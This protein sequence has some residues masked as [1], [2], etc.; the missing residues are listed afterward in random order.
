MNE[1]ADLLR[2]PASPHL[3]VLG[4]TDTAV[5]LAA[6]AAAAVARLYQR[7]RWPAHPVRRV[8]YTDLS[9]AGTALGLMVAI[10][11]IAHLSGLQVYGSGLASDLAVGVILVAG[12]WVALEWRL[13]IR[14]LLAKYDRRFPETG[15]R[16]ATAVRARMPRQEGPFL[17]AVATGFVAYAAFVWHPWSH[18]LHEGNWIPGALAGYALGCI[19][20]IRRT[21]VPMPSQPAPVR[22]RRRRR[23]RSRR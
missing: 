13:D 11:T 21:D 16:G 15:A 23:P 19:Y 3:D 20:A 22:G 2:S 17:W 14:P 18:L 8:V 9:R 4:A 5:M 6:L 1:F 12:V 7:H 10:P